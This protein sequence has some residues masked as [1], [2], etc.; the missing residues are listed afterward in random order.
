MPR[1]RFQKK[2]KP[3]K[4]PL[5]KNAKDSAQD[6]SIIQLKKSIKEIQM[7]EE[8]KNFDILSTLTPNT[9][10]TFVCLNPMVQGQTK[11]TRIGNQISCTSLQYRGRITIDA[12]ATFTPIVRIIFF[13][14]SQANASAVTTA[15]LLDAGII[16][17]LVSSPYN[18]DNSRRFKV[19]SDRRYTVEGQPALTSLNSKL[20]QGDIKLNRITK[21]N[22]TNGGTF[23]DITTNSLWMFVVS[24]DG[25]NTPAVVV[26]SRLYFKDT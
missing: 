15:L 16:T 4:G 18:H 7:N 1:R 21:F 25:T 24:N 3:K 17:P 6:K 13:W 10:G 22:T 23:A 2:F 19:L 11:L 20:I 26:G 9:A 8:L 14:D 12:S 5:P